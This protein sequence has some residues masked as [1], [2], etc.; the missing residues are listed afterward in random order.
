MKKILFLTVAIMLFTFSCKNSEDN[1]TKNKDKDKENIEKTDSPKG[2]Y[3]LKSGI[4]EYKTSM[5]GMDMTQTLYFD[6]YGKKE[7][8]ETIVEM[9]GVKTHSI[10]IIKDGYNYNIDLTQKTGTKTA[11]VEGTTANI[12]FENLTDEMSKKMNLKKLGN[13][14]FMGKKCE[15]MSIDYKEMQ[16]K[17]T[18]LVYKGIALKVDLDLGSM[19]MTM[20]A[21]KFEENPNIPKSKFEVPD[22]VTIIEN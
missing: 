10:D 20:V 1:S 15:K 4:V 11:F 7:A 6:N 5:M 13:E 14:N 22:D 16:M 18:F 2:K 17:G 12:D 19:Q 9:M 3:E 8:T 21:N